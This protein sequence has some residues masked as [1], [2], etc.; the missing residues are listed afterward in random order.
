MP[1]HVPNYIDT[2]FHILYPVCFKCKHL[3]DGM[4]CAAFPDGDG[5]PNE[6]I[7][8]ENDHAVPCCG[9]KNKIVFEEGQSAYSKSA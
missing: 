2:E 7:T 9:Q 3:R 4:K 6:I 8:R 1:E 5:I